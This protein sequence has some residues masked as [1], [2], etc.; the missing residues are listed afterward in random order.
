MKTKKLIALMLSFLTIAS[1]FSAFSLS[2]Q[3]DEISQFEVLSGFGLCEGKKPEEFVTR[4]DMAKMI[5]NIFYDKYAVAGTA[6]VF[7]DVP[8][9]HWAYEYIN[10]LCANGIIQGNEGKFYPDYSIKLIDAVCMLLKAA[11]YTETASNNGGYPNG[12]IK[13]SLN[14]KLL[15]QVNKSYNDTITYSDLARIFVNYL[16]IPYMKIKF[17]GNGSYVDEGESVLEEVFEA[18]KV[19]GQIIGNMKTL[20]VSPRD[21]EKHVVT[22]KGVDYIDEKLLYQKYIGYDVT[23]YVRTNNNDE[24]EVLY[25]KPSSSNETTSYELD[26][27]YVNNNELYYAGERNKRIKIDERADLIY[28]GV[29]LIPWDLSL[30]ETEMGSVTL[31][32]ND[33]DGDYDLITMNAYENYFVDYVNLFSGEIVD[34]NGK[35]ALYIDESDSDLVCSITHH[36]MQIE[37]KDI[38]ENY[39]LSVSESKNEQ[40]IKYIDIKVSENSVVGKQTARDDEWIKI[41]AQTYRYDKSIAES[42]ADVTEGRFYLDIYGNIAAYENLLAGGVDMD[43]AG[44]FYSYYSDKDHK[45]T[46]YVKLVTLDGKVKRIGTTKKISYEHDGMTTRID[47]KSLFEKPQFLSPNGYIVQL[48]NYSINSEGLISRIT[49]AVDKTG[50]TVGGAGRDYDNFSLDIRMTGDYKQPKSEGGV[51]YGNINMRFQSYWH[52]NK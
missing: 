37:L 42:L 11:G 31:L 24:E 23:A 28:N 40:G 5:A 22:I 50:G 7:S 17:V 33:S 26:D 6:L 46:Y 4:A 3:A 27:F 36:D 43:N 10:I 29:T 16:D 49:T 44:I 34:K 15:S 21:I 52:N 1:V 20:L 47:A 13:V 19:K 2:A 41:N 12:Y 39:V 45:E 8:K 51:V 14:K 48:I 18:K 38:K 9:N 25:V 32:D 30:F 35:D